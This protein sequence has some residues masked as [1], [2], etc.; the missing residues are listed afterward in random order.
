MKDFGISR[1]NFS[2]RRIPGYLFA[3]I[4]YEI[5]T[6]PLHMGMSYMDQGAYSQDL[7]FFLTCE[8]KGSNRKQSARWQ[9]VSWLKAS[10]FYIW[11]NKLW[12][13]KTQQLKLGLVL[14]SGG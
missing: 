9:H 2:R 5:L 10:A 6:I 11:S 4:S 3:K 12:W 8:W 7:I 13:F 14:P 1:S